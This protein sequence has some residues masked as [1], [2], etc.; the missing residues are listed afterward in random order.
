MLSMR[1]ASSRF[2]VWVEMRWD[3]DYYYGTLHL[4]WK[5][6]DEAVKAPTSEPP[7]LGRAVQV[8]QV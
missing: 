4:F 6:I 7:G 5:V 2:N 8:P 1:R 3:R